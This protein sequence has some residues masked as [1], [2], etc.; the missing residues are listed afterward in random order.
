MRSEWVLTPETKPDAKLVVAALECSKRHGVASTGP[1][2]LQGA[3]DLVHFRSTG[4]QG[5]VMGPG[6][7]D[8]GR[9]LGGIRPDGDESRDT[10]SPSGLDGVDS[11]PL[12]EEVAVTVSPHGR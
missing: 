11:D 1:Y 6:R 7:L 12:V 10:G 3:C 2:G 4:A 9:R 5:I 8:G